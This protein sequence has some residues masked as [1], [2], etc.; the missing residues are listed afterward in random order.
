MEWTPMKWINENQNYDL[1]SGQEHKF[2]NTIRSSHLISRF[3]FSI[4]T[5]HRGVLFLTTLKG[6]P[7]VFP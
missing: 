4:L 7:F 6:G 5:L 2:I 1:R 3:Y